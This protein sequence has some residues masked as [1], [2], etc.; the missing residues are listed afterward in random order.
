MPPERIA[1][2]TLGPIP[3]TEI[4]WRKRSRSSSLANPYSDSESSRATRCA[5]SVAGLPWAGTDLSVSAETAS[6]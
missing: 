4:R 1:S 2:A 5:C 6:R 3:D